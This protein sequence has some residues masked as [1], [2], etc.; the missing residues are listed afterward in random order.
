[1]IKPIQALQALAKENVKFVLIGEMA[2]RSH[3]SSYLTQDLD[4]C[5]S[6]NSENLKNLVKVLAPFKPRPRNFPDKLFFV[7]DVATLNQGTN[8]TFTT[9]IGDIDLLAEVSGIGIYEDALAESVIMNL[10]GYEINVLSIEGLIKAKNAAGRKKDL[11]ILPELEAM[12]EV[13]KNEE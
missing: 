8:F 10:H 5:F 4:I 1:M 2:I 11:D 13:L 6:R 3:G 12:K 7:W 9:E